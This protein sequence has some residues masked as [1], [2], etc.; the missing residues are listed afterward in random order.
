MEARSPQAILFVDETYREATYGAHSQLDSVAGL[1][2]RIVTG[3]SV[4]KAL[5]AP[6]LRTGWLTV[7]NA[8]LRARLIGFRSDRSAAVTPAG[9]RCCRP[10]TQACCRSESRTCEAPLH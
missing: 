3:A 6:G 9:R 2:P 7:L 5:G 8:D 10:S 1:H 4:S